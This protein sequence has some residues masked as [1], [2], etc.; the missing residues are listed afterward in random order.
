[1][2]LVSKSVRKEQEAMLSREEDFEAAALAFE[3]K[4]KDFESSARP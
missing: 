4:E 2:K 3:M 1:M